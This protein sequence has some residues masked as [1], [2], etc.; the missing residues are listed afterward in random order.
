MENKIK[1]MVLDSQ[2]SVADYISKLATMRS[3][4]A[5]ISYDSID[6]LDIVETHRPDICVID[7]FLEHSP[8]NGI[9]V[10]KK[11][12]EIHKDTICIMFTRIIDDD[13]VEEA[14]ELGAFACIIK[15]F[16]PAELKHAID[17]SAQKAIQNKISIET[18]PQQTK[19]EEKVSWLKR[20]W[21]SMMKS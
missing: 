15:P 19:P 1:L 12:K 7:I 2:E 10:L 11:I 17:A 9:E 14:T 21:L 18:I 3:L 16:D 4:E 8:L 13:K 6:A 5:F 20:F